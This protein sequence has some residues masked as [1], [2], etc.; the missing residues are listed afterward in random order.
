[1]SWESVRNQKRM[2]ST[3]LLV[4]NNFSQSEAPEEIVE[5]LAEVRG[6]LEEVLS[7]LAEGEK[8]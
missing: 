7:V 4:Q 1:M 5:C 3:L 8:F 2:K 6:G